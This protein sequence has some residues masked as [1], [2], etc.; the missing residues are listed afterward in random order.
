[1]SEQTYFCFREDNCKFETLTREQIENAIANATGASTVDADSAYITK[2]KESNENNNLTFWQGTEAQF[3]AL[4]I[5]TTPQTILIDENKKLY[6]LP[7]SAIIPDDSITGAKI[8][9]GA[10]TTD[11]V[12]NGAITNEKIGANA[13]TTNR[14]ASGAVTNEKLNNNAVTANKISNGA[15]TTEKLSSD[16]LVP[17]EKGG[18]GATTAGAALTNLGAQSKIK[19]ASVSLPTASWTGLSI[20]ANSW[21]QMITIPGTTAHSKLDIEPDPTTLAT[22]MNEGFSLTIQNYHG[23]LTAYAVG[24]KPSQDLTI[25]V[26]ITEVSE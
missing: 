11:K 14:I 22:A 2:I 12:A 24:V 23:N 1:M 10:V 3:N 21:Q 18:T 6:I 7:G 25:Q 16:L 26:S 17:I 20:P 9:N 5:T 19:I 4:K 8:V 13:I 15:I